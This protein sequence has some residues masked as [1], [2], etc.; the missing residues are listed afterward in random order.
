MSDEKPTKTSN[1][2][3]TPSARAVAFALLTRIERLGEPVLQREAL[4]HAIRAAT[5]LQVGPPVSGGSHSPDPWA[6]ELCRLLSEAF[7]ERFTE[8]RAKAGEAGEEQNG[9]AN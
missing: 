7:D 1:T 3:P 5:V 6:M 8:K 2:V 4:L 9:G